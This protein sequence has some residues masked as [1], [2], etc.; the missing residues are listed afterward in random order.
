MGWLGGS[1]SMDGGPSQTLVYKTRSW[2]T[3][4]DASVMQLLPSTLPLIIHVLHLLCVSYS[5][6]TS[7]GSTK[8]GQVP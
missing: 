8:L 2:L 7:L 3:H 6:H 1:W 4:R 5:S